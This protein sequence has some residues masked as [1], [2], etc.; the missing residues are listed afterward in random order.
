MAL[1]AVVLWIYQQTGEATPVALLSFF[2][3]APMVVVSLFSGALVDRYDRRLMMLMSDSATL[4]VCLFLIVSSSLG[5]LDVVHLYIAAAFLGTFQTFQWPATSAAVSEMVEPKHY[6]R[7]ASLLE[8]AGMSSGL[9]APL[10]AGALLGF[11]GLPGVLTFTGI[12][13]ALAIVT[14]FLIELPRRAPGPPVPLRRLFS[15]IREGID[16]VLHRPPLMAIQ[17]TFL[18]GNFFLG[19]SWTLLGPLVLART[20]ND[21]LAFASVETAGAVGGL[22]GA[23]LIAVWGGPK[24]KVLGIVLGWSFSGLLGL[25]VIGLGPSLGFWIAGALMGAAFGNLNYTSNQALWQSKVDVNLQG[26]VFSVRR[27]IAQAVTPLASLAAGPLADKVL[28]P[29]MK[30]GGALAP[31]LGPI[32]GT[33]QG[34]GIKVLFFLCGIAV[35]LIGPIAWSFG[36]IRNA[37]RLLPNPAP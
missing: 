4:V 18:A 12:G 24:N 22:I 19:L 31:F 27:L 14:L 20:A 28:E 26:R 23:S 34:A 15:E 33:G 10:L 5:S 7:T 2:L 30:A 25:A 37:E 11:I 21:A 9:L 6:G 16:F 32:F 35:F 3:T 29:A 36:L 13:S 8:M 1:F 17:G